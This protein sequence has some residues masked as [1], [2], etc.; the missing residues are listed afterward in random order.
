MKKKLYIQPSVEEV[1][2]DGEIQVYMASK[3]PGRPTTNSASSVMSVE[4][5]EEVY[6]NP[7]EQTPY[8]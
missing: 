5:V 3:K 1:K 6:S 4:D 8:K 2:V 7:L